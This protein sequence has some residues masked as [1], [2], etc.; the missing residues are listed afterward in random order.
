MTTLDTHTLIDLRL[1]EECDLGVVLPRAQRPFGQ[2]AVRRGKHDRLAA[3][4]RGGAH[5]WVPSSMYPPMGVTDSPGRPARR[6]P[7]A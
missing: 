5:P 6:R 2:L 3:G 1:L 4:R 7:A